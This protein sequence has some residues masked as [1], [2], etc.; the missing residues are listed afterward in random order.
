MNIA[1]PVDIL[2]IGAG[3]AGALAAAFAR[4]KGFSVRVLEKVPFPR[5]SI[6]ESLLPACMNLLADAGMV[7]A[8]ER[9][10]FQHKNGAQIARGERFVD[11]EFADKT[12][13]GYSH[14][15]EVTRADFDHLLIREAE[16]QGAEVQFRE[17]IVR[18]DFSG[19]PVVVSRSEAG[20]ETE[21]RAR[22]VCDAS[23]F[24]RILPRMLDLEAP[25][26]F[27]V[28]AG[29]FTH[30]E[31][32]ISD[33][34]YDRNKIR[35][36]IHPE[37]RDIWYWLIPFSQGRA[38]IGVVAADEFLKL[39]GANADERLWQM[40]NE[41]PGMR[42]LLAKA[43]PLFPARAIRGYAAKV[44]RL[45]GKGFAL[46]GN[47][48]EFLDPVFSSGVT[49]AMKSAQLAI[50]AAARELAGETVDWEADYAKPLTLGVDTFRGYVETWYDGDLQDVMFSTVQPPRLRAMMCSVLAGYAWD[51]DNPYCGHSERRLRSLAQVVRGS[52]AATVF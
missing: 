12:A 4:R 49:I 1:P 50:D 26:D 23:G 3:P 42:R 47:A 33:P 32:H 31:D 46:L 41:E 36:G 7:E 13:E 18:V 2:V 35:V 30:V 22:F 16:K 10:G 19:A 28:R 48:G 51:K 37:H 29:L 38:S 27:P 15:F 17:E 45:H 6:G 11:F 25:S 20:E 34:N 5:F 14:T 9:F 8:V 52:G 24:G 43:T 40:I 21:H 39:E 44:K